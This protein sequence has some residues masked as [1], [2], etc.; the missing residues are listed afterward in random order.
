M[1]E[2]INKAIKIKE[3]EFMQAYKQHISQVQD[4]IDQMKDDAD[5]NKGLQQLV[6]EGDQK[7]FIDIKQERVNKHLVRKF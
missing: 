7:S 3:R 6:E 5:E 1:D 2:T 4:D